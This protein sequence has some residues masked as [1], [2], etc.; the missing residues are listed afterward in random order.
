M[1]REGEIGRLRNFG[2]IA[3]IDAG[4]TTLTER[5]LYYTGRTHRLGNVD[6]G[7]TVTDWMVQEQ[8]RG[9]TIVS[10]AITCQWQEHTLALIDTPGHVDFTAEVERSLR[11]LDGAVGVFCA[12]GGVQ[13]QSE[14]VWRQANRYG[15]P[16]L[17]FVNKLDRLGADPECCLREMREK[18]GAVP[19][20]LQLP[21]GRE[22]D[23]RG[24]ID[25]IT[26]R[27]LTWSEGDGR[28][29][30][31]EDVPAELAGAAQAARAAMLE[32]L[33]EHDD[34]FLAKFL[35]DEAG[36]TE[37]E[38]HNGI[39]RAT[40]AQAVTPTYFGAAFR[41]RGVQPLLDGI[42]RYLPSPLD[43]PPVVG[44]HPAT[45]ER[46][47]RRPADGEPFTALVF[48][49]DSD[50][51]TDR[52][53]YVRVYAGT[54]KAGAAVVNG[55][56]GRKVRLQKL[57][58]LHANRREELAQ[59]AT[60]D[61]IAVVGAEQVATGDTLCDREH[62]VV[63]EALR[64]PEPVVSIAIEPRTQAEREKLAKALAR[65][66]DEDPT[67]RVQVDAET[68]QTII[69]GMGELHLDIKVDRLR[70]EFK[71]A[72][73]VGQPQVAY[74]ETVTAAVTHTAEYERQLGDTLHYASVTLAVAPG[75]GG[76]LT[77]RSAVT[78]TPAIA[79]AVEDG[80]RGAQSAGPLAGYPLSGLAVTLVAAQGKD[81]SEPADY[82][83]AAGRALR[84]AVKDGQPVLLEPVMRVAVETPEEF[85]GAVLGSLSS[86]GGA[87]SGMTAHGTAQ[88]IDVTVP[89]RAMFGYANELRSLTQGRATYTMEFAQFAPLPD[90]VAKTMVT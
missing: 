63:L 53:V 50:Q 5:I 21:V 34:E 59:A 18:L 11:V 73:N 78:L 77:W 45:E 17:A 72:A 46:C 85:L 41:N 62:P 25:L 7:N 19:L 10:A 20:A 33:A 76:G 13:P 47:E 79:Q 12:A 22:A 81:G 4:K 61:I 14:T 88:V 24:V 58:R 38:I 51:H 52:L 26:M 43:L 49:I 60:G 28:T 6:D 83:I 89:L 65:L 2:I 56:T 80:V 32:R 74:Q 67:F 42:V 69:G 23:F 44:L 3:H 40:L 75:P 9:I 15:V 66:A 90:A 87:V 37:E 29:V 84:A 35:E 64:F 39:R 1:A 57:F 8:E 68:G 54:V 30:A 71:V 82:A 31:A 16:R 70:R 36:I 48:K 55:R 86:R 27:L